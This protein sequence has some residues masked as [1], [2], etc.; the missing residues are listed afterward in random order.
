[1]AD[2]AQMQ[3]CIADHESAMMRDSMVTHHFTLLHVHGTAEKLGPHCETE[4]K[5]LT[6]TLT[7]HFNSVS[8]LKSVTQAS[9]Q[10][11]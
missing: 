6:T 4:G 3:R 8:A 7:H 1:M 11:Q 9:L 10:S 5:Q 2:I